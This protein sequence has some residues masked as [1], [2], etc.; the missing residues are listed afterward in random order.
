[1]TLLL[2]AGVTVV[3]ITGAWMALQRVRKDLTP[4]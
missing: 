4:R 1:V 3:T 2:L